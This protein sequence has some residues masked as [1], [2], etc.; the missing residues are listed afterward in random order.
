MK[1]ARILF[2]LIIVSCQIAW[3]LTIPELHGKRINDY[4]GILSTEEVSKLEAKLAEHEKS[5]SNQIVILIMK[6]LEDENLEEFS[7][8]VAEKWKIGQKGKDNGVILLFFMDDKKDRIEVGY[9]L[10]SV[11]PDAICKRIL[12]KEVQPKFKE[13][14]YY[15]GIDQETD[16][17]FAS[18][19][20]E[21]QKE[22]AAETK[23][24]HLLIGFALLAIIAGLLGYTHWSVSSITGGIG[25][26]IVWFLIFGAVSISSILI[27]LVAGIIGGLIAHFI[28]SL[29]LGGGVS[30]SDFGSGILF[31][32]DSSG[33]IDSFSSGGGDFGGG[34]ASGGW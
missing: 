21:Y 22:I 19:T 4:A 20:G 6:S 16:K 30:G 33:S 24:N 9:G 34:G 17:I 12:T 14:K 18:I 31:S 7:G 2:I 5:S 26:P 27:L 23:T 1:K 10:E 13:K 25:S 8:K 29:T 15:E 3:G 32:G 28:M 11:L